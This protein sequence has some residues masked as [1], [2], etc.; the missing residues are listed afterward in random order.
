M[1]VF[2]AIMPHPPETVIG[3]GTPDQLKAAEKTLH[4]FDELRKGLEKADPDTLI[5]ISPHA[6]LEA[7]SFVINSSD[8]LKG[9]LSE[10]GLEKVQSYENDLVFANK[11]AFAG[12]MN[13]IPTAL[14]ENFLDHGALIPL[15]H[16]LKNI[17]PRVVHLSF[18]LMDYQK[19][20]LYGEIIKGLID[21]GLGGRVAV[22]ASAGLSHKLTPNSP[23]GYSPQAQRFDTDI[24]HYLGSNDVASILD[25]QPDATR[26]AAECGLRSILI[27]LGILHGVKYDFKLLSYEFPIGIGYLTARLI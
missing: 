10:F 22:I 19:Q 8:L 26:E 11:L 13:D 14:K 1:L 21:S 17:K 5:I 12:L 27:L 23:A 24:L 6:H 3:I 4:S 20:F 2:A 7:Y 25:L 16:L 9:S 15:Y 18:S